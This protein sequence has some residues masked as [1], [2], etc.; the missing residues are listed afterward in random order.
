MDLMNL[1]PTSDTVE[2]ILKH[3]NTLDP[4]LNDDGSEMTV[5]LHASHSKEYK[6]IVHEQQDRR[7]K[8]MQKKAKSQISAQDIERDA[9][10]LLAKVTADWDITYG[11]EKPKLTVTKAKEVFT[12]VFWIREQIE[13]AFSDSMDFTTA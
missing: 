2:V 3:P 10:D 12:E 6:K 5:T 1:K 13:E 7:I 11:G 4:L 9:T 8:M